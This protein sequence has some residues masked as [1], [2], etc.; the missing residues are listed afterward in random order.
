MFLDF[1][2]EHPKFKA[3]GYA[4]S[5]NRDD[6]R[7]TIEGLEAKDK[8]SAEDI[9]DFAKVFSDADEFELTRRSARCWYD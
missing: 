6:Y 1:M 4:V 7:I 8:L 2:M 3:F 9:S 5:N